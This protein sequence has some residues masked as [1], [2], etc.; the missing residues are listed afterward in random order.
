MKKIIYLVVALTCHVSFAQ[1]ALLIHSIDLVESPTAVTMP[2]GSYHVSLKT[3][4]QG[5][6]LSQIGV[7]LTDRF[8]FGISFGGTS[9][10]GS[11]RVTWNP[12]AGVQLK[13]QISREELNYPAI[14][15]GYDSQGAGAYL[16][17]FRRY[18][19]KSKG[20]YLNL[21][22]SYS[23]LG[24]FA[25][26]AG[27]SRSFEQEDGDDD[28]TVFTGLEKSLNSELSVLGEY[29]FATNDNREIVGMGKG[30]FHVALKW[31]LFDKF[32][33]EFIIRDLLENNLKLTSASRELRIRYFEKF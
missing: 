29:N 3:F 26:H 17:E 4:D 5:G 9:V 25:F 12:Q 28:L 10:L 21:S 27:L 11:G 30:Y 20:L 7:S 24:L 19:E 1:T 15:I 22:K 33:L 16:G 8:M 13:Y 32:D 23:L 14:S 18:T 31:N 2:K 6:V